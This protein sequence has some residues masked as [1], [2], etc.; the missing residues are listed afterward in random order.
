MVIGRIWLLISVQQ[1]LSSGFVHAKIVEDMLQMKCSLDW[2]SLEYIH[3]IMVTKFTVT[4][5]T[6]VDIY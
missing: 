1:L 2:L 5:F 4:K 3:I 6:N